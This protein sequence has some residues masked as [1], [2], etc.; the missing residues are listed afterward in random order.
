MFRK[1]RGSS[2]F[3]SEHVRTRPACISI[4]YSM[5]VR[6]GL[7]PETYGC[8]ARGILLASQ[9]EYEREK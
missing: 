9:V 6:S 7:L 3:V 5:V 1:G 2:V 8:G 4:F